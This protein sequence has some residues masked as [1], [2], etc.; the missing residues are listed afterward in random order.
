MSLPQ[1]NEPHIKF[2]ITGAIAMCVAAGRK[3]FDIGIMKGD[4]SDGRLTNHV[5]KMEVS[6]DGSGGQSIRAYTHASLQKEV[7]LAPRQ[8]ISGPGIELFGAPTVDRSKIQTTP[9][10]AWALDM[11]NHEMHNGQVTINAQALRSVLRVSGIM[12]AIF[13]TQTRR[14]EC[15][16]IRNNGVTRDFGRVAAQIE[17]LLAIPEGGLTITNGSDVNTLE[18]TMGVNYKV[19]ISHLC[20]PNTCDPLLES[21]YDRLYDSNGPNGKTYLVRMV[22][23]LETDVQS[24]CPSVNF[25][26]SASL[27][28]PQ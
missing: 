25:G 11:E 27:P 5:L 17:A 4:G 23:T 7:F 10:F 22:N 9:D 16:E 6:K 26:K 14:G 15:L 1:M 12:R 8:P 3:Q 2:V 20:P 28:T 21:A 18:R 24:G 13:Y 19:I